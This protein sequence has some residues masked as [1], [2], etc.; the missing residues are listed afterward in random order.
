MNHI[1]IQSDSETFSI[2]KENQSTVVDYCVIPILII[3]EVLR[4]EGS[5][6]L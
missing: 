3:S 1:E 6:P 4:V 2:P 5:I